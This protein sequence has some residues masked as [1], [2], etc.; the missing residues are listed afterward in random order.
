VLKESIESNRNAIL[1]KVPPNGRY[2]YFV[3]NIIFH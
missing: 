1:E 3:N 2:D